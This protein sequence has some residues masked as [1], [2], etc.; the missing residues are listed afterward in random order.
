MRRVIQDE[1]EDKLSESLLHC[2]FKSGDT[3]EIDYNGG[4]IAINA[5]SG[6]GIGEDNSN[7][8]SQGQTGSSTKI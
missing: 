1:I 2:E 6:S 5:V 4:K 3:I 7:L 8:I